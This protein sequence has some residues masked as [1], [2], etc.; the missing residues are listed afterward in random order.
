MKKIL[1]FILLFASSVGFAQ[2][3]TGQK[4][5]RSFSLPDFSLLQVDSTTITTQDITSDKKV[6][7]MLFSP[8][9]DHC[10]KETEN[11]IA[12]IDRFRDIEI[13]MASDHELDELR[14]YYKKY[15]LS[16][17]ANIRFGK[18]ADY[19]LKPFYGIYTVPFVA[20]YNKEHTYIMAYR[21]EP[22][23]DDILGVFKDH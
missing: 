10:K 12:H 20:L 8:T 18:D 17:Y 9:C 19:K 1:L 15:N 7:I 13:V 3:N 16:Q 21:G 23:V 5:P 6:M 11:I 4:Y 2:T 22:S 14:P